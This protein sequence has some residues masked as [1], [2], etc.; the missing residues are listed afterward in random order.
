MEIKKYALVENNAVTETH[1]VLPHCWRNISGLDLSKDNIEF[2]NSVGWY[3]IEANTQ[4]QL[5]TGDSYISEYTYTFSDNKVISTPV[6]Q[7]I[8][9]ISVT[10][11]DFMESLRKMRDSELS[12]TDWTQAADVIAIKSDEFT[13]AWKNYRQ[14]LR[15]IT[16]QYENVESYDDLI[17]TFPDKPQ[18]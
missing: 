3:E 11:E 2:L 5:V 12:S 15:D 16:Q 7:T 17:I 13:Q 8:T 9:R 14:Q 18:V 10:K 1:E 4:S 6:I